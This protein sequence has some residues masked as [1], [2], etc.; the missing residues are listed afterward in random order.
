MT[1][2]PKMALTVGVG[3]VMDTREVIIVVLGFN[4]ALALRNV[5]EGGISHLWTASILQMHQKGI[6][7]VSKFIL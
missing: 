5:V 2:V 7:A 4:K 6:L 3:T 1:K